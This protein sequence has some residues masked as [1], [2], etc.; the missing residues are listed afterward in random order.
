MNQLLDNP[1]QT[2]YYLSDKW[3]IAST[4]WHNEV[5]EKR[6]FTE[7][8]SKITLEGNRICDVACG[9]GFH[10]ILLS[11]MGYTVEAVDIDKGNLDHFK[12][13]MQ[14][15]LHRIPVYNSDWL[16][17]QDLFK[18]KFDS[19]LCLGSSIT[20]FESWKDGGRINSENRI[21][22]LVK[23]LS[24]FKSLC[25]ENGKVVIGFSKH[26]P[27]SKNIEVIKFPQK[28]GFKMEWVLRFDWERKV[29]RWGCIL[30]HISGEQISFEL[31]SHLYSTEEFVDICETVFSK[32]E[33]IDIHENYYDEFIVCS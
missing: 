7:L 31:E 19:V 1:V 15:S 10:S 11:K 24:N 22:G 21:T 29:K 18:S 25:L 32:V 2:E 26:Y 8:L 4:V 5:F 17:L 23:V 9:T 3:N 6:I 28:N 33:K 16:N 12:N 30:S 13:K 27:T 20:Y 14:G